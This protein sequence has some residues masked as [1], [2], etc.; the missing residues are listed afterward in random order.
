MSKK[1]PKFYVVWEGHCIGVFT[2]WA[3]CQKQINGYP[4]AVYKSFSTRAEAE[5]AFKGY[6][7]DYIGK[8]VKEK[9]KELSPAEIAKYGK[10]IEN[11]ITVDG[12]CSGKTG[13]SEYQAVHTAEGTPIFHQG[14]FEDG[15]NNIMEFLALVHALAYCKQH[16][17]DLPIY[18]DSKIAMSWV[19]KKTQRTN[20]PR[21]AKNQKIF[22]M[23][24]RAVKWLNENQYKNPILKW[25]TKAWGENP[26][27]FGRK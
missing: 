11:S 21:S 6:S 3:E 25:E 19:K 10:P 18:S 4:K 15:T 20:H 16:K 17:L 2:S 8:D 14:T 9:K 22:E 13:L 5:I 12:A 26:A 24:D 7:S 23:L 1:K 27:D